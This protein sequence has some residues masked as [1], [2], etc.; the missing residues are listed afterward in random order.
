MK[1]KDSG[2]RRFEIAARDFMQ[3][4]IR[5]VHKIKGDPTHVI[6]EKMGVKTL[7]WYAKVKEN[8]VARSVADKFQREKT[9]LFSLYFWMSISVGFPHSTK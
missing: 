4:F 1:V 3:Q 5:I 2:E 7:N 6:R 9:C 8:R